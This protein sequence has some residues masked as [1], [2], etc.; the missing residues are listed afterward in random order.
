M[1][2]LHLHETAR[3]L[4]ERLERG[5]IKLVLAESCT[6]GRALAALGTVSGVSRYLCGGM[7]VY[8]P[9]TKT[10]WLKMDAIWLAEVSPESLACSEALA[11]AA[12]DHTLEA[13]FSLAITGDLDPSATP[14]KQGRIFM[15]AAL[16]SA[17]E[18][19]QLLCCGLE[20]RLHES[21]RIGRQTEAAQRL[22]DWGCEL[23]E[24]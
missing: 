2:E 20:V 15:A 19:R 17:D 12:L 18:T 5:E 21:D 14:E 22:L 11:R 8:R 10:Q 24:Q 6:C 1:S 16:R 7:V 13:N 4:V 3:R 9:S 23:L